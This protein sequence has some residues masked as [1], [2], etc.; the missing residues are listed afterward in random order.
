VAVWST[1]VHCPLN[2]G[3][4]SRRD[5]KTQMERSGSGETAFWLSAIYWLSAVGRTGQRL[6][7]ES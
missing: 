4:I 1:K 5:A 6:T 3:N 7:A 2:H